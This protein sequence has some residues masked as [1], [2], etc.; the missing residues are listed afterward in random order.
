MSIITSADHLRTRR[1]VGRQVIIISCFFCGL[2]ESLPV[3]HEKIL[4]RQE[5]RVIYVVVMTFGR[6]EDH[7]K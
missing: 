1:G 7:I 2:S 6:K 3:Y 4:L 5:T